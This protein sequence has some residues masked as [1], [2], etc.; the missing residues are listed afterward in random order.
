MN[1]W[2]VKSEP[3]KYAWTDLQHDGHTT[4]DGVRN[5]QA[6]N[7]LQAMQENDLVLYY[8]SVSEKA[9]VGIAKVLKE[10]YPEPGA[11]D[12]RWLA[13]TLGPERTFK[14]PVTLEQIKK[15]ETLQ[16]IALLRQSRLSVMPVTDQEFELLLAMGN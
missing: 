13:V 11:D 1:Y 2:L 15:E 14:K 16:N 7:N 10:A 5:Y 4:W 6:R 12:P 3:D 8:H 9:V